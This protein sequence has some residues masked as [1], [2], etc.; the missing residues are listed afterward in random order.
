MRLTWYS[1]C[2]SYVR[3]RGHFF[4]EKQNYNRATTE[5][6]EGLVTSD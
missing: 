1:I 4:L 6:G 5:L 2:I 3:T